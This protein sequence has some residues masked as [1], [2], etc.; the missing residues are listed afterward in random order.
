MSKESEAS[1]TGCGGCLSIIVFA[2]VA[3][4]LIFGVTIGGVHHDMSCSCKRGVEVTAAGPAAPMAAPVATVPSAVPAPVPA[5]S[6]TPWRGKAL[7][8]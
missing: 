5:E 4:A 2:I 6:A 1:V 8:Q 7:D 3:W